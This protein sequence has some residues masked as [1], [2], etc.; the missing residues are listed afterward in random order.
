MKTL[1]LDTATWDLLLDARGNIAV[2]NDPYAI[3][4]N[5]ATALRTFK[6]EVWFN[7]D[8]GVPYFSQ[9]LGELPPLQFV[10]ALLVAQALTVP[11][12]VSAVCYI[13]SFDNRSLGGQMQI[14]DDKGV[15]QNVGF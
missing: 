15:R 11:G 14:T 8:R 4:Q 10:K 12:V 7:T 2:A 13:T 9:V 5:V 1:L 3:A 6:G